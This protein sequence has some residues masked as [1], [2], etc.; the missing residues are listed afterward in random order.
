MLKTFYFDVKGAV[1]DLARFEVRFTSDDE[2]IQHCRDL[3]ARLRQRR[4]N[5]EAGLLISVLNETGREI[6]WELVNPPDKAAQ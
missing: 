2:A 5:N 3:A 6:H 4:F 1:S